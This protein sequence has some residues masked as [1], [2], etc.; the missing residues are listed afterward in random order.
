MKVAHQVA[1][2]MWQQSV[3]VLLVS[4]S[5]EQDFNVVERQGGYLRTTALLGIMAPISNRAVV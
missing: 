2:R 5:L 4:G 1:D 3:A